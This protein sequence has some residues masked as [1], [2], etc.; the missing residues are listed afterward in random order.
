MSVRGVEEALQPKT[1]VAILAKPWVHIDRHL[2][3]L[4]PCCFQPWYQGTDEKGLAELHSFYRKGLCQ[5]CAMLRRCPSEPKSSV[6]REIESDFKACPQ[7]HSPANQSN[8]RLEKD[9][10]T[11]S[12][13]SRRKRLTGFLIFFA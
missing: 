7:T 4:A 11:F 12:V 9:F 2:L 3:L 6:K 10:L 5:G 8:N 1:L 13:L